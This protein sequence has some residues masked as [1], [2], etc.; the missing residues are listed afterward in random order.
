MWWG[1]PVQSTGPLLLDWTS[2]RSRTSSGVQRFDEE[3]FGGLG[4]APRTQEKL[5][6]VALRVDSTIVVHPGF[7]D[8]D[9]GLIH[10]PGVSEGFQMRSASL[11]Q[12]G[13]IALNPAIPGR[14]IHIESPFP[15]HFFEVARAERITQVPTDTR[16]NDLGFKVAPFA[17]VQL[18]H[19]KTPRLFLKRG[20]VYCSVKLSLHHC[21]SSRS[22]FV[23]QERDRAA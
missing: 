20:R 12:F 15:H 10:F 9:G 14:M 11:L 7:S 22:A 5:Q 6:G 21:S 19:E 17:R 23:V 18:V 16:E 13:G 8:F 3:A 4:I 2:L 1:Q